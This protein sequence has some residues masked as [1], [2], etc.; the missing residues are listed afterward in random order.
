MDAMFSVGGKHDLER[1]W[2]V[3][4]EDR[5][6]FSSNVAMNTLKFNFTHSQDGKQ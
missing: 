6:H 1:D 4:D 5:L 3:V 2:L